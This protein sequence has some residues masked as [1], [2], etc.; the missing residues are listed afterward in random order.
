M[1]CLRELLPAEL[2]EVFL[3]SFFSS[4]GCSAHSAG[5]F[6]RFVSWLCACLELEPQEA[7]VKP[8]EYVAPE[9]EL[10]WLLNTRE[11]DQ[12]PA[13]TRAPGILS[14]VSLQEHRG[15]VLLAL[16]LVYEVSV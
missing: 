12:P 2:T 11:P 13:D 14:T 1:E 9:L 4:V 16:H 10:L 7:P 3:S 5:L 8:L 15:T 6:P